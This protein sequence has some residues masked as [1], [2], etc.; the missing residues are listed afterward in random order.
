MIAPPYCF[1]QHHTRC[2]NASRPSSLRLVPPSPASCRSTIICV[3][4]PAWSV[5][6][7]H[8]AVSPASDASASGCPSPSGSACGPCAAGRSHSGGG[9]SM[10]KCA[11]LR[12]RILRSAWERRTDAPSPSNRPSAAR[13]Q[14]GRT[15]SARRW[16]GFRT[17][18]FCAVISGS[19]AN[20][21]GSI[22]GS[23]HVSSAR[24]VALWAPAREPRT[25]PCAYRC[26]RAGRSTASIRA[27]TEEHTMFER[28]LLRHGGRAAQVLPLR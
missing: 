18:A 24:L 19:M 17:R 27:A 8:S 1:F 5:P 22:R 7:T 21:K 13:W 14:K 10:V 11:A 25:H 20:V 12:C 16:L 26:D 9:S 6:G 2:V 15:L 23:A 3:A 4:M 28:K